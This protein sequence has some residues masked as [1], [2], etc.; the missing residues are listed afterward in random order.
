MTDNDQGDLS[1]A[2]VIQQLMYDLGIPLY[3]H[4]NG[5][6]SPCKEEY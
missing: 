6:I 2:E 4:G 1:L 5:V 3:R